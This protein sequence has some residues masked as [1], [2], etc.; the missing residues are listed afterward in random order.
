MRT[1]N[2]EKELMKFMLNPSYREKAILKIHNEKDAL[3]NC[4]IKAV[5]EDI[6]KLTKQHIDEITRIANERWEI[7]ISGKFAINRT[8]GKVRINHN[9]V[10]FSSIK[11]AEVNAQHG[12]RTI[13]TNNSK[14]KKH[15]SVG[16]ALVGNALFGPVGA[17]A[18]GVGLGKTKTQ[19]KSVSNQIP[20]CMH[21]G[22]L[23][24]IDGFV[25]EISLLETQVDQSSIAF[26]KAYNLAQQI[27]AQLG[28]LSKTPVPDSYIKPEEEA[29]VKNIE[30]QISDKQIELQNIIAN[31]P[32]YE[33][34]AIYR[35]DE[36]KD[37]SDEE[38]LE[39]LKKNDAIRQEELLRN[40]EIAK[41]EKGR[42]KELKRKERAENAV[43]GCSVNV[44]KIGSVVVD[45]IFW[46]LSVFTLIFSIVG[47]TTH[48][49]VV[50][51]MILIITAILVNPII[52]KLICNKGY[53]I[54]RWVCIVIFFV[55]FM[56][57]IFTYPSSNEK[58]NT[59]SQS[60]QTINT[61]STHN[62]VNK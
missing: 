53:N 54:K 43:A 2:E 32:T 42:L 45:V 12:F 20:T 28:I 33:L 1:A 46:I 41:Q 52:Y 5:K 40:K 7:V 36:Q 37:M 24:D 6:N 62:S 49:G 59:D 26:T 13:T 11:G 17:I 55:G 57:G 23:V 39:Y 31:K 61:V 4:S 51:G 58:T 27:V 18:G 22:V 38:Y 8:E 15:A 34:P 30:K 14:S 25:S 29:S 16:G 9:D 56:A 21:L 47:F 60:N 10:I 19:G 44:K 3:Y 48:G 50:S 35:S